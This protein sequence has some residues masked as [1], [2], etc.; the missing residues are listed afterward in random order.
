MT[1]GTGG[2]FSE[3]LGVT[4]RAACLLMHLIEFETGTGVIELL[5]EPA[6][7]MAGLTG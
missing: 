6:G 1:T 3:T 5:G 7:L 2:R 4:I